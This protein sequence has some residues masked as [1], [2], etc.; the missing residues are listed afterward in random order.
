MDVMCRSTACRAD[1]RCITDGEIVWSWRLGADAPRNAY[2]R[3][4]D[5]MMRNIVAI[6]GQEKP[7]PEESAYKP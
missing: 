4:A 2:T 3:C 7:I 1:E 5:A 6:R